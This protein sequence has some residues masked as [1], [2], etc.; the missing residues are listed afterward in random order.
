MS[1]RVAI[2]GFGRIGRQALKAGFGRPEI[3]FVAINDLAAVENLAYLLRHDSVY[4]KWAHEVSFTEGQLVIDGKAI[5][6]LQEKE[7]AKLPWKDLNVDVVIESTGR[8]TNKEGMEMHLAAGAKKVILSAPAKGGGVPTFVRGVNDDKYAG[9][10]TINNASCTTNCV[11]PVVAV[12]QENLG[13]AKALMTTIHAYT[14]DQSL[15]D[16][17]HKDLRR[18]RSAAINMVPTSTGAAIAVT[19]TI[20]ELKG[21]FDGLAIRV[22]VPTGSLVDCTFVVKKKTTKEEVNKMLSAAAVSPRWQGVLECSNE[23]LVSTDIIGNPASS[24]VDLALTQVV[25]GDLVKVIIWYD[26]EWGYAARLIEMVE[27][28]GK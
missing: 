14:A 7:P 22:P 23:A 9:E 15:V 28:I 12:L 2:N 20:T 18:G 1:I 10:T 21:M 16:G 24:I 5:K 8:F 27:K 19:E 6:V 11:A 3:E 17:P 13:I 25:D 4:G 26:N